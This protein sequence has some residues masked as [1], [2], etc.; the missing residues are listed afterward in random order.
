MLKLNKPLSVL[1]ELGFLSN[2]SDEEFITSEEGQ[3]EIAQAIAEGIL[4][5]KL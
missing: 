5:Y 2:K 1:V 3:E 4:K